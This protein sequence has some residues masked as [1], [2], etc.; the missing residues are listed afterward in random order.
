MVS[1]DLS[2]KCKTRKNTL[3]SRRRKSNGIKLMLKLRKRSNTRRSRQL[4]KEGT[5]LLSKSWSKRKHRSLRPPEPLKFP[6][7]VAVEPWLR[8]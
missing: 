5:S 7:S 8:I 3:K 6:H 2:P 4:R 1:I